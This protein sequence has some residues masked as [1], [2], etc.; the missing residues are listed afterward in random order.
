MAD[1]TALKE[2][3]NKLFTSSPRRLEEARDSYL[4]ALGHLPDLKVEPAPPP[5][6]SGLQELTDDEAAALEA[7]AS[8]PV[9][10]EKEERTQLETT[11]REC[12]KAV[13][14]NLAAVY[15]ALVSVT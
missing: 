7:E 14:G 13:W 2:T 1:A 11:I 10:A 5:P 3:G 15:L 6:P 9:D 4:A 8:Q 12:T